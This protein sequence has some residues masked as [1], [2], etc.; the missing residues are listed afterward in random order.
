MGKAY[1]GPK[2]MDIVECFVCTQPKP[3]L[4]TPYIVERATGLDHMQAAACLDS[5]SPHA[6]ESSLYEACLQKDENGIVTEHGRWLIKSKAKRN[7]Y[8]IDEPEPCMLEAIR[9]ADA[10]GLPY[11]ENQKQAE[12][13][14]NECQTRQNLRDYAICRFV[15]VAAGTGLVIDGFRRIRTGNTMGP[16]EAILGLLIGAFSLFS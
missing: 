4:V 16:S 14:F 8:W 5:L 9:T 6:G 7:E 3:S 2:G 1:C 15:G 10:S 11:P 13:L 12:K